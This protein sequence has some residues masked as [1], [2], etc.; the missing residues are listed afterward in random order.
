MSNEYQAP[1]DKEN[2]FKV[3]SMI[4]IAEWG[5]ATAIADTEAPVYVK[6]ALVGDGA[7]I[8]IKG[9]SSKG[10]APGTIKGQISNNCFRG[11]LPIPAKVETGAKIWF[12]AKLPKH[13]ISYESN[14][15]PAQAGIEIRKIQ[16]DKKVIHRK[17]TVKMT[18]VFGAGVDDGTIAT[19]TVYE[20]S[21]EGNHEKVMTNPVLVESG[22]VELDW[23]FDY[24]GDTSSIPTEEEMKSIGKHYAGPKYFFTVEV[25]GH[26]FGRKQESGFLEFKDVITLKLIAFPDYPVGNVNYSL[27]LPDGKTR[28]GTLDENGIADE[29]DIPPGVSWVE[30]ED[31]EGEFICDSGKENIQNA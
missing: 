30:F 5:C 16:W 19:C 27:H 2:K 25:N 29:K 22:K 17:E 8:E 1:V 15:I 31:C 28:N 18:V 4:V 10:K 6:T 21:P 23:E 9:K 26:V 7:T 14:E 3:T 11:K 24:D 13:G 20:Y 12:E